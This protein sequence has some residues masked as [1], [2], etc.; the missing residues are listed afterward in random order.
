[1]SVQSSWLVAKTLSPMTHSPADIGFNLLLVDPQGYQQSALLGALADEGCTVSMV[2]TAVDAWMLIQTQRPQ[3]I[4][5]NTDLPDAS[6][7]GL[8]QQLKR[9]PQIRRIPVLFWGDGENVEARLQSFEVGGVD[10]IPKPYFTAEVMAR[11]QLKPIAAFSTIPN[12][13]GHN[14]VTF[15]CWQIC[16]KHCISKP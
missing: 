4:L 9:S 14:R 1:M 12:K 8:C 2:G 6:S 16:K 7:F 13:P 3:I 15:R 5:L 11:I 10:F